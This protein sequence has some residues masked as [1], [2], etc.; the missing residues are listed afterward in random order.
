MADWSNP[1]D[2]SSGHETFVV[3]N[4]DG[5]D[6]RMLSNSASTPNHSAMADDTA[7]PAGNDDQQVR[8]VPTRAC[9][10]CRRLK[11]CCLD[12]NILIT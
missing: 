7:S 8:T 11:V 4:G 3:D 5:D 2:P 10:G 9:L 1:V 12:S 6:M